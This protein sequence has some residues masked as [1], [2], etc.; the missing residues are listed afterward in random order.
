[1]VGLNYSAWRTQDTRISQ[2][3]HVTQFGWRPVRIQLL[4]L[5]RKKFLFSSIVATARD[6]SSTF[7]AE[8]RPETT[9]A[10]FVTTGE[11]AGGGGRRKGS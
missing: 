3:T 4:G 9:I 7:Q 6:Q 10:V 8:E 11:I 2:D 1:M 5:P